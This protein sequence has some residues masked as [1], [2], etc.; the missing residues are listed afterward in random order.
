MAEQEQYLAAVSEERVDGTLLAAA[1]APD[2]QLPP[3]GGG[4]PVAGGRWLA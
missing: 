1:A 2:T 4:L 3:A